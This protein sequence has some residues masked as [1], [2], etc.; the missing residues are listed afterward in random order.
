[1]LWVLKIHEAA[2]GRKLNTEKFEMSYSRNLEPEKINIV[3]MKFAFMT[4]DRHD[5]YLGLPI[6]IG[7]LN[8]FPS[9]SR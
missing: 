3:Q 5:K 2:F 7:K 1:M 4:V 6:F 9:D 8:I